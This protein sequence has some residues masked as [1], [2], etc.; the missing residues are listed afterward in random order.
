MEHEFLKFWE[1]MSL[2]F[3]FKTKS[4]KSGLLYPPDPWNVFSI[5][6]LRQRLAE[7]VGEW[8]ATIPV[9]ERS[10]GTM[11]LHQKAFNDNPKNPEKGRLIHIANVAMILWTTMDKKEIPVG[12]H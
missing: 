3:Q 9:Q 12:V 5:K 10:D 1:E 11:M 8:F 7:E 6:V 4:D 2:V